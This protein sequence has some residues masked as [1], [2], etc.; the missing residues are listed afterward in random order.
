MTFLLI[1]MPFIFGYLL[2]ARVLKERQWQLRL[3]V[4][5]AL[6]LTLFLFSVNALFHFLSLRVS[7]YTTVALMAAG[8]LGLLRLPSIRSSPLVL[9]KLEASIVIVLAM[10]AAFRALFFQM[11]WVDD[12]LFPHGP[13]M[14]LYLRDI[15]P[16]RNPLH[17]ELLMLGHYGRDL[18]ISALSVLLRERF[19]LVQYL[20][21]ALNQGAIVLLIYFMSRR[22]LGSVRQAL[23][24]MLLAFL[25]GWALMEVFGN[26][27]SFVYLFL[28]LNSYLCWLALI[29]RDV[30]SKAI[31]AVSLATYSIVYETHYGIL[32]IVFSLF[33]I[34]LMVRRRRWRP[35]YVEIPAIVCGVSL[36]IALVHGG[37]LTDVGRRLLFSPSY[38]ASAVKTQSY[39]TQEV[40]L[41][42][43]K[44]HFMITAADG[45]N[46]PVVSVRLLREAG[47]FVLFVPLVTAMM[48]YW[49]RYWGV[50]IATMGLVAV[51]VPATVDFGA[52]NV[53]S[54]RFLFFGGV[55]A[56]MACGVAVGMWLDWIAPRGPLPL[57]A[58]VVVLIFLAV[59]CGTAVRRTADNF[60]DVM[61]RPREY[62]WRAED[63]A[64]R[65]AYSARMCDPA[66]ARA[67][68]RLRPLVKGGES[69]MLNTTDV[70]ELSFHTDAMLAALSGTFVSGRGVRVSSTG[71]YTMGMTFEEPV[72]FRAM[73]FWNTGDVT[74]LDDLGTDYLLV[75]PA[76]LKPPVYERLAHEG[77]LKLLFR[78]AGVRPG[79]IREMYRVER[80]L[81]EPAPPVPVDLRLEIGPLPPKLER[82]RFYEI[83]LSVATRD[84]GFEGRVKVGYRVFLAGQLV[85]W[86]D[87]VRHVI[88]LEP[89]GRER[90][91]GYLHFVAPYDAGHYDVTVEAFDETSAQDKAKFTV[92]VSAAPARDESG[93]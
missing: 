63:W 39:F 77:R 42:F 81:R 40:H 74:L 90:W 47:T 29:R 52:Q 20:V 4:A 10:T 32:L 34:F 72:G 3:P 78:E 76:K 25:G 31:A 12:D 9:G 93:R 28:F 8:S 6:A 87:E 59:S 35:R 86:N 58:K 23:L 60:W 57:W 92:T 13:L 71:G 11:M 49:R 30:A 84:P 65:G 61:L 27:N 68:M 64:C 44:P 67:V 16:P 33:P 88:N 37:T 14:A 45:A 91:T 56:A 36:A 89:A 62:Y 38:H 15:F 43:P 21:T 19:F 54:Y 79:T 7:V 1:P 70:P 50:W 46:Y 83:P 26:N 80:G 66:D 24:T 73:A 82:A 48:I 51:L 17:P 2:A 69:L 75:D 18:T 85:N 53:E 55:A 22:F 41:R 5:Y